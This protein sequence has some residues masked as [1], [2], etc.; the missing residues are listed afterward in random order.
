[1][2]KLLKASRLIVFALAS[3]ASSTLSAWYDP[4]GYWGRHYPNCYEFPSR[5][6]YTVRA[7]EYH[8]NLGS[9]DPNIRW[10]H[11]KLKECSKQ[12]T[13]ERILISLEAFE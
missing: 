2:K 3:F 1:M 12:K 10:D 9:G 5:G 7:K 11:T 8:N 13:L 6:L 4:T